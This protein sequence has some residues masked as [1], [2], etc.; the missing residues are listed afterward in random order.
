MT[1]YRHEKASL[2]GKPYI[3][4]LMWCGLHGEPAWV[5]D[6]GSVKCWWEDI[7]ETST[8][9]HVLFEIDQADELTATDETSA[10]EH[11]RSDLRWALGKLVELTT[12]QA[13]LK[14]VAQ[15]RVALDGN[16]AGGGE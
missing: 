16:S 2:V 5:Y 11:L 13:I 15:I 9:E 6:D 1:V 7:V 3:R 14:D 10:D 8:D 4:N 12:D